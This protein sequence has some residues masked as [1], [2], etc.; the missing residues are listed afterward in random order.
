MG[1]DNIRKIANSLSSDGIA[2]FTLVTVK[3]LS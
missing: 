2:G 1:L 3:P